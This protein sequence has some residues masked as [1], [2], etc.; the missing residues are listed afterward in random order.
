MS[1]KVIELA[2]IKLA[3]S[4]TEDELIGASEMFQDQFLNM[5]DGFIR[6]D[7]VRKGDGS[8]MD[9]IL[10]QSRAHADAIFEKAKKSKAA[11]Q[12]FSLMDYDPE[13]MDEGVEHCALL[14]SF[15]GTDF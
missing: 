3:K 10:W 5:Q 9:I 15:P 14:N 6:R 1:K 13:K 4:K 2:S 8:Y 7:F 12:F 11:G